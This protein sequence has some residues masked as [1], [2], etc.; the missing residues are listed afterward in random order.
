MVMSMAMMVMMSRDGPS[1]DDDFF[2][3]VGATVLFGGA[4]THGALRERRLGL[5]GWLRVRGGKIEGVCVCGS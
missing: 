1:S 4:E 5:L 3:V 2:D